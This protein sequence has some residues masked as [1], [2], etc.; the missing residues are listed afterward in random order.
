[1]SEQ[2]DRVKAVLDGIKA[3][4]GKT[5]ASMMSKGTT[6]DIVDV[7]PTGIDVL[8]HYI[9]GIGGWPVGRIVEVYAGEGAGKTSLLFQ[10]IAGVQREGGVATLIETE[11]AID[12]ERAKVF[13]CD[14]DQVILSQPDTLEDALAMVQAMLE[15]MP[16]S[17]AG[18]PPNF[19][20]WD[21]LAA[22]PTKSEV[23]QGA[24][25]SQKMGE[26]ARAMSF[27][28]RVITR[29]CAEKRCLMMIVNQTRNKLGVVFGNPTTTPGGDAL[30]FH[31]SMRIQL[32]GGKAVKQ[33]TDHVGKVLTVLAVKNKCG[34]APWAKAGVRLDY[35]TGWNNVWSTLNYAKDRK[36]ID[37]KAKPSHDNYQLAM[38][39]LG[40]KAGFASSAL[41]AAGTEEDDSTE[42][43][44]MMDFTKLGG[45]TDD[46]D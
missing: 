39:Q 33:G 45:V 15:A 16:K 19:I 20:G 46:E 29:L 18:S 36:A 3:K 31:A 37:A 25:G 6:S 7:I 38:K 23:E 8:D 4:V 22:T 28:M 34:G 35:A 17:K 21:S 10:T 5:S 1:M 44:G 9:L 2:Q 41:P 14:V 42:D 24:S 12:M 27:A 43:G 26:R 30:K 13:G 40:W 32:L 11:H